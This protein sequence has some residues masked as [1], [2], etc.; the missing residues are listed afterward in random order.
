[1]NLSNLNK[2]LENDD[3]EGLQS[4]IST[5]EYANF[6][7]VSSEKYIP[8][9]IRFSCPVLT[10]AVFHHAD[11]CIIYLLE[12]GAKITNNDHWFTTIIHMSAK[13]GH[14]DYLADGSPFTSLKYDAQDWR[15]R[16]PLFYAI[17]AEKMECVK[18]LVDTKKV[19]IHMK[20]MFGN[21]CLHA[22]AESGNI[23][24]YSFLFDKNCEEVE[25]SQQKIPFLIAIE[26]GK[27]DLVKFLI[28]RSPELKNFKVG[29][30]L[31]VFL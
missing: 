30:S 20:D 26:K 16:T 10:A 2:A 22:A 19:D 9:E 11:N 31:F 25:N 21:N 3:V 14:L 23:E 28:E 18:F 24:I 8:V 6:R 5:E 15:G 12:N 27:L 4:M 1:M 17:E 13:C 7:I 29:I